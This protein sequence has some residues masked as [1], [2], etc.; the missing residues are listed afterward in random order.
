MGR[1]NFFGQ[2]CDIFLSAVYV[3]TV[4]SFRPC[5]GTKPMNRP[6]RNDDDDD[7]NMAAV[8]EN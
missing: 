5:L 2:S 8:V 4:L 7:D 6:K 1:G 3:C